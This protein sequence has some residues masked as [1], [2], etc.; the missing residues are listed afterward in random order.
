MTTKRLLEQPRV[1]DSTSTREPVTGKALHEGAFRNFGKEISPNGHYYTSARE[2]HYIH[3][4][5]ACGR[6]EDEQSSGAVLKYGCPAHHLI[7]S[8]IRLQ[9]QTHIEALSP[10]RGPGCLPSSPE[11][12]HP[13]TSS[14]IPV[15][16]ERSV[17]IPSL[18][19]AL[20]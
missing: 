16:H 17:L 3:K 5:F 7:L 10:V 9:D 14:I 2:M 6:E 1:S 12:P 15:P 13:H 11:T 8:G 19:R 20:C 4:K 18:Q